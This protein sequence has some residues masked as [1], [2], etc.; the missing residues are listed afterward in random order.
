MTATRSV[1]APGT[2]MSATQPAEAPGVRMA[3]QPV[4]A[5]GARTDVCTQPTGTGSGDVGF[6]NRSPVQELLICICYYWCV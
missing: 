5:P 4:E 1:E 3:T 6:V 2:G